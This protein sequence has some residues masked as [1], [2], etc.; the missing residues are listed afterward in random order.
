MA[1]LIVK[2]KTT[3]PRPQENDDTNTVVLMVGSTPQGD[4]GAKGDKG[5]QGIQGIQ[6]LKG[7]KGD[8]GDP[9]IYTDFTP[10]QLAALKGDKGDKGEVGDRG[11]QG[12]KGDTGDNAIISAVNITT[13]AA[14][15]S[16]TATLSG[17]PS[18]R[19]FD[20]TIPRGDNGDRGLKGDK[21]ADGQVFNENG[22]G[23]LKIWTGTELQYTAVTVKDPTTIYLVTE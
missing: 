9:F 17:T 19:V 11:L 22:G 6:G 10:L 15:T 14:G 4:K 2:V 3:A 23:L 20:L 1:R 7:D 12:E 5:D 13:G 21:G 8:K 16:A 18:N